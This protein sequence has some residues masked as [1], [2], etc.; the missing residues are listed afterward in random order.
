M[1]LAS[2]HYFLL[3]PYYFLLSLCPVTNTGLFFLIINWHETVT[4]KSKDFFLKIYNTWHISYIFFLSLN[5]S[6]WKSITSEDMGQ[7]MHFPVAITEWSNASD[8]A[9]NKIYFID[10][11]YLCTSEMNACRKIGNF[12]KT[13]IPS[14][15]QKSANMEKATAKLVVG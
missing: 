5:K 6:K 10:L 12:L 8:F 4:N 15:P 11:S 1:S 14:F 2:S 13:N 9:V 7:G 3:V